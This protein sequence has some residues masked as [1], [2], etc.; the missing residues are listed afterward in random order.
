MRRASKLYED[1]QGPKYEGQYADEIQPINDDIVVVTYNIKEGVKIDQAGEGLKTVD[2][3]K[4]ADIVLLQ[5][6]D[7]AGVDQIAQLLSL[8]Y[9]YY[10]AFISRDG[11]NVGNAILARWPLTDTQKINL[12]GRHPLSGQMRIAVRATMGFGGQDLHVYSLHTETYSTKPSHRRD[13]IFAVVEDIGPGEDLV[14]VGGDLNTVST[15]SIKRM[16]DQFAAIG[17]D[18][19]SAGSGP[20]ISKFGI[21]SVT[22]DHILA[23][24]FTTISSGVVPHAEASDHYPVWAQLASKAEASGTGYVGR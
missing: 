4:D 7:E 22:A 2:E 11:R 15:R 14:I 12:P 13:Q 18:S 17:L 24:G 9:V 6:M 20:T 10:P 1:P 23:R 3:L 8:N 21:S 5:E 16:K 19:V